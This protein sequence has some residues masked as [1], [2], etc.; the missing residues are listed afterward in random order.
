MP[1]TFMKWDFFNLKYMMSEKS[2]QKIRETFKIKGIGF[3]HGYIPWNKGLKMSEE[4]KNKLSKIRI[5]HIGYNKGIKR[6]QFSGSNHPNW[7]GGKL[8]CKGRLYIYNPKHP[9]SDKK[10]YILFS[11]FTVEKHIGRFLSKNEIVHHINERIED[12]RPE[13]L[14]LF[15]NRGKHTAYHKLIINNKIEQIRKSNIL[16]PI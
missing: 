4:Y 3:Q 14:Y 13:N 5:G 6:P 9:N 12:D 16:L 1:L 10:G 15:E 2:K 8:K 7:K 11:R